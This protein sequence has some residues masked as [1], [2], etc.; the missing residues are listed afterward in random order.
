MLQVALLESLRKSGVLTA[1]QIAKV[2]DFK[3]L[4]SLL[5][6]MGKIPPFSD[7]ELEVCRRVD[8]IMKDKSLS[9]SKKLDAIEKI[10]G[11]VA[12]PTTKGVLD[13][14]VALGRKI[15]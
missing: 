6:S 2:V 15:Y 12:D 7:E 3:D 9:F 10:A 5:V 4:Y 14:V 8:S 1:D 13:Q 11:S